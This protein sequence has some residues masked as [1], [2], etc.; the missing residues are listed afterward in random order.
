MKEQILSL[1][2]EGKSYNEIAK[3]LGCTKPNVAYHCN[4]TFREK[5]HKT[6]ER[7]RQRGMKN[8]KMQFGGKCSICNYNKCLDALSFHHTKPLEKNKD[9]STLF[10]LKGIAAAIEEA[11]K[12][13]L[14]CANCHAEIHAN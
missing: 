5:S 11:K 6:R 9:V 8:I 4:A 12:C 1:R 2:K 10:R 13:L 14:V 3:L 7:N